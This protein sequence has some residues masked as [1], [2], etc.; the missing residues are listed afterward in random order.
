MLLAFLGGLGH[1]PPFLAR[2]YEEQ[3]EQQRD[4]FFHIHVITSVVWLVVSV[5]RSM[6]TLINHNKV[7]KSS[8]TVCPL[9]IS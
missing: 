4:N 7:I 3:C 6:G 1:E 9:Y 5:R 2:S 8:L